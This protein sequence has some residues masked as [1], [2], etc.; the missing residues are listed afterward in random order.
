MQLDEMGCSGT[1]SDGVGVADILVDSA[2]SFSFVGSVIH[3]D[4][5]VAVHS[6]AGTPR[7]TDVPVGVG[8]GGRVTRSD[9]G[10]VHA[11]LVARGKGST[12][13]SLEADST[14][15]DADGVGLERDAIHHLGIGGMAIR[16]YSNIRAADYGTNFTES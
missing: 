7:V 14:G 13:V 8:I 15:V 2:K 4:A 11:S 10:V 6:P 5:D 12:A 3:A 9:D 16:S 1:P